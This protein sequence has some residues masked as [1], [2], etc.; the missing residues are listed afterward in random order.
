MGVAYAGECEAPQE[1]PTDPRGD[2]TNECNCAEVFKPV[3]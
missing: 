3:W 2:I 1:L